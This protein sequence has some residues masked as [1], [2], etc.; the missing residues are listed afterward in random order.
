MIPPVPDPIQHIIQH[1]LPDL[2]A[3]L[4]LVVVLQL[5]PARGPV[6]APHRELVVGRLLRGVEERHD[7]PAQGA[8]LL[9]RLLRGRRARLETGEL[10][11]HAVA[12]DVA[13]HSS[14][15][16]LEGAGVQL[17]CGSDI[18]GVR[19]LEMGDRLTRVHEFLVAL[20]G[21][22]QRGEGD[23]E[24]GADF[25]GGLRGAPDLEQLV[26]EGHHQDAADFQEVFH[27]GLE[28]LGTTSAAVNS[29][30]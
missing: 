8:L 25:P 30:V 26:V 13:Y 1:H 19:G 9:G 15:G 16:L 12:Q 18:S 22:D 14:A 7:Q 21:L 17:D 6:P 24:E 2:N 3:R 5:V 28:G 10:S 23:E 27:V 20:A 29:V 4:V 11:G